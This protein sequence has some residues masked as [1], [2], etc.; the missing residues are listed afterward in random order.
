MVN[1]TGR[2]RGIAGH[3]LGQLDHIT[4]NGRL[5]AK[6][7]GGERIT[8]RAQLLALHDDW[9]PT[10]AGMT[11]VMSSMCTARPA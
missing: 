1:L 6:K 11:S 5:P 8:D 4:H 10:N 2:S 7:Q 3:L 9:L